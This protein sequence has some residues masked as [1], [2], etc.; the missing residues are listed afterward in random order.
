MRVDLK[1]ILADPLQR[2]R[3]LA[4]MIKATIAV[5]RDDTRPVKEPMPINLEDVTI[6]NDLRDRLL[7]IS[8]EQVAAAERRLTKIEP[9]ESE[10]GTIHSDVTRALYTL[11]ITLRAESVLEAAKAG[12]Q[13][14]ETAEKDHIQQAA[15]LDMFSD[16]AR[17]LFWAQA[18]LDVGFHEQTTVGVRTG[19]TMV[20]KIEE[21]G[22]GAMFARIMGHLP[23]PPEE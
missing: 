19:W 1:R 11:W 7:K 20:K 5:G 14:D 17:E 4:K 21:P 8:P 10:L 6:Y 22:P 15:V 18:K 16:V 23:S 13:I 2:A 12:N 9:R 3:L